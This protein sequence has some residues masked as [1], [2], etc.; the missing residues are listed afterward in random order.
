[1]IARLYS[2]LLSLGMLFVLGVQTGNAWA[3]T[4][5]RTLTP[6]QQELLAPLEEDWDEMSDVQQQRWLKVGR[7][8]ESEPEDKQAIM[9]ERVESWAGLSP[10][11]KA[12]A[13]ENYKALQEKRQG[14]R[15]SS[16]NS[17]QSLDPKQRD[18]FKAK[19]PK[20]AKN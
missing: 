4:P 12:A 5:W 15:N 19:G 11:E 2:G 14:E 3:D 16:W 10:R 8:Y 13:R 1:M 18:E 9:R 20:P 7:K 17:Y 6:K